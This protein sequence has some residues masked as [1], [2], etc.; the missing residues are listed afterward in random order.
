MTNDNYSKNFFIAL[1]FLLVITALLIG[2]VSGFVIV[3]VD[4]KI[5]DYHLSNLLIIYDVK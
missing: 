4:E 2:I 5:D 3:K 1:V